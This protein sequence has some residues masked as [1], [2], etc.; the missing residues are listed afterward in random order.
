MA[1][2]PKPLTA[3]LGIR[4]TFECRNALGEVIKTITILNGAIPL[5]RLGLTEEQARQLVEQQ[6]PQPGE[7]TP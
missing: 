6:Q 7:S 1:Y 5:A 2:Q 4:G 3:R